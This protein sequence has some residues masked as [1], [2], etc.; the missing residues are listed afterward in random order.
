MKIEFTIKFSKKISRIKNL[1]LKN[2]IKK[3]IKKISLNPEIGKPMRYD[4]LGSR[5][6]YLGSYRLSYQWI[7][8]ENFISFLDYYHKDEQ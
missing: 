8:K 2:R 6:I 7:E 3:Q 4:R 5:E 1:E